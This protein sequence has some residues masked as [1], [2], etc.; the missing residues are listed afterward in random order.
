ML[1]T[2]QHTNVSTRPPK[3]DGTR[4]QNHKYLVTPTQERLFYGAVETVLARARYASGREVPTPL[5]LTLEATLWVGAHI[6]TASYAALKY[7][8]RPLPA[9]SGEA[10]EMEAGICGH[11]SQILADLLRCLG[12]AARQIG[13]S[14]EATGETHVGV[15]AMWDG[16]WHYVDPTWGTYWQCDGE[17]LSVEEIVAEP[18]R[19]ELAVSNQLHLSASA[20]VL[21][22]LDPFDYLE[23]SDRHWVLTRGTSGT[24]A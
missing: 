15:E 17:V 1:E 19:R 14:T 7:Q 23:R 6:N 5:S 16:R 20:Y 4:P 10:L 9:N 12:V 2:A 11:Q 21:A 24:P 18:R 22:G 8:Q 3:G 13:F